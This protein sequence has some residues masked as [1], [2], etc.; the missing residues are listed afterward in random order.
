MKTVNVRTA[1]RR[2]WRSIIA[3]AFLFGALAGGAQDA[4]AQ[5]INMEGYITDSETGEGLQ[6]AVIGI[7]ELRIWDLSDSTGLFHLI[8]ITPGM[9]RFIALR[10][11]YYWADQDVRFAES[12]Q[13]DITMQP[14]NEADPIGPGAIVGRIV[15]QGSNMF[16]IDRYA[17]NVRRDLGYDRH[18]TPP[19]CKGLAESLRLHVMR[20]A[21]R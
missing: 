19:S 3:S 17:K 20:L 1:R 18:G 9:Y 5:T 15:Q 14:E 12:G 21:L 13:L 6:Y 10:R 7:P 8:G 2:S 11:G 4:G 16:G